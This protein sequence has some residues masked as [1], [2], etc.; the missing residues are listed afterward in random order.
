MSIQEI[1]KGKV[2]VKD[3]TKTNISSIRYEYVYNGKHHD[4]TV[5]VKEGYIDGSDGHGE[6]FKGLPAVLMCIRFEGKLKNENVKYTKTVAFI[7]CVECDSKLGDMDT[8]YGTPDLPVC[9]HCQP[10]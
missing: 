1:G 8:N 4:R 5:Y 10:E 3:N 2:T 6:T 7:R 9:I